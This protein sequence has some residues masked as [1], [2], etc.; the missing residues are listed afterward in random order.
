MRIAPGLATQ[1]SLIVVTGLLAGVRS[2]A[3]EDPSPL[4]HAHAH[5]DYEHKLPLFDALHHGFCSVEADIYLVDGKLLVA[6]D[7][8][9]VSPEK[10]LQSLYLDPLRAR[11]KKNGGRVYTGGPRCTL[12]IDL[13]VDWQTIY[14]VLRETF[15]EYSDIFT[16]FTAH[17]SDPKALT[18]II[19]GNRS[20]EMFS[21]ET[22]RYAAY[23]GEL[24]DLDS[25]ASA[26]LIPWISTNWAADFQWRGMGAMPA[27][28]KLKLQGLVA[29]AHAKGRQLR[30]W[31]APDQPVFWRAM[32][33][34]GV[35]LINTDDLAG[36][37]KFFEA[38]K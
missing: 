13:K 22:V 30:F 16:T 6:H 21:G 5:N 18:A 4:I 9:K 34:N 12:L 32:L 29:K 27:D 35:D 36:A 7:R 33:D 11:I 24:S 25:D 38:R 26:D 28:E 37:Q 20:K 2:I 19:T 31:G 3:A 17:G 15:K 8:N 14:P 10:T 23:D 1:I